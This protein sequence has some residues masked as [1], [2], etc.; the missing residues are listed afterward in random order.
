VASAVLLAVSINGQFYLPCVDNNGNITAYIE[1]GVIVAEYIYDAFGSTIT[2]TGSISDTFHH[3]FSTKYY[4]TETGLYYYGY[5]SMTRP[6][7]AGSTA[8]PSMKSAG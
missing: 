8:I 4:D 6:S 1:Q 7:T 3:R 2:A 5:V